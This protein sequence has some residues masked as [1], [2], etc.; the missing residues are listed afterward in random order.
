MQGCEKEYRWLQTSLFQPDRVEE[1]G[2]P[3]EA[4]N[5]E[6]KLV[7]SISVSQSSVC[8]LVIIDS[9]DNLLIK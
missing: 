8:I 9:V 7:L 2:Q 6:I 4:K 3:F 5:S 1:V